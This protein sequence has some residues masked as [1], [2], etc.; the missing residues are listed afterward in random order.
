MNWRYPNQC[1]YA[2]KKENLLACLIAK[3]QFSLAGSS[4]LVLYNVQDIPVPEHTSGFTRHHVPV[5]D[6]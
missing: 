4:A 5:P 3:A 2:Y 6:F 1:L